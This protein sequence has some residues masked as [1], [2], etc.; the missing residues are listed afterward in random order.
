MQFGSVKITNLDDYLLPGNEC[1]VQEKSIQKV[2]Q[3]PDLI[4]TKQDKA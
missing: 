2:R 3:A 4:K 1:V